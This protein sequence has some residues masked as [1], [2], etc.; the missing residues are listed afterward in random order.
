MSLLT[1]PRA[2]PDDGSA[3]SRRQATRSK[4]RPDIDGIRGAAAIMVMGYHADVP[5]FTGAYIGLDLFFVVSGFVITNLLLHEFGKTGRIRW[6]A[7]YARR[8]RRL[9]PAK[10]TMLIGV[11]LLSY[12]VMTPTGSQQETARSAAAAGAFVSNFFFW[13]VADLDYFGHEPGTGVLL[14]T[15]SLS[16]EEQFYLAL[17][18][19]IF[20]AWCLAKLLRVHVRRTLLF[21]TLALG[22]ASLWLAMTWS[23]TYPDAAYY[24]PI[25]RAFEFLIGV[26]LSL[27]VTKL[28]LPAAVRQAMGVLG[29]LIVAYVLWRPMPVD[30]YPD[31]WALLP[32]AAAMLLTWAGTGG[33]TLVTRLLSLRFLVAL[34]LVSYGWYLWHWP[35][36]VMGESVNLAPP[37]LW[38]RIGLVL[39]ALGIAYLSYRYI[40]GRFY[41][42]SGSSSSQ[43]TWG[44]R[45]VVLA[46][47]TTMSI[48]AALSGGAFVVAKDQALSP[49]WEAVASQLADTPEMPE[50]CLADDEVIPS[51]PTTC[52]LVP[53]EEGRA[54]IV[55]WGDSHAWMFIPALQAAAADQDV[56][57]VAFVMGGCPPFEAKAGSGAGCV[58]A[59]RLALKSVKQ[60]SRSSVPLRVIVGAS[61]ESY[62]GNRP[63]TLMDERA[64]NADRQDYVARIGSLFKAGAPALFET[65][66]GLGIGVDVIGPTAAIRRNAPLCEARTRPFSCDLARTEAIADEA[67]TRDYLT[68]Q[69]KQLQADRRLI[70]VT[71]AQC[72]DKT[73]FAATDGVVYFFDDNHFSAT[74]ARGLERYFAQTVRS[75]G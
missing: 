5:G 34:G 15:W 57:L 27:V 53:Y 73:C 56:N 1:A 9:I 12:F 69:M 22:L 70:D 11:L 25:T 23:D 18:L 24:L 10:A 6:S 74:F 32:C 62:L 7:F 55:L 38:I 44:N 47:V 46:G 67:K 63:L 40:E 68:L 29:V 75:V 37:P 59:N 49:R 33:Q 3:E 35:L 16:V 48:V 45:R 64:P 39:L 14:H 50:E 8:A 13:R 20:L 66:G 43:P 51:R 36:L 17:P 26:A 54:T 30:G 52:N 60:L 21:T 31:Y 72:D 19:V 71:D 58:R 28:H 4:Y 2:D 61:W 41:K 42:R 65:L